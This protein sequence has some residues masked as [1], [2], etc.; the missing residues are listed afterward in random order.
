MNTEHIHS[1]AESAVSRS[2]QLSNEQSAVVAAVVKQFGVYADQHQHMVSDSRKVQKGDIFAAYS[3]DPLAKNDAKHDG[4]SYAETAVKNGARA[5]LWQL[6]GQATAKFSVPTGGVEDLNQLA[7]HIA[8]AYYGKPSEHMRMVAVTGTNGKTSCAQWLAQILSIHEMR[9]GIMGTL[10]VGFIN[11]MQETG[12]TT[13][14]AIEVHRYLNDMREHGA[15]A[16]AME[17]SSHALTQGRVNGVAYEVALF[18]NLSRDHLDYHGDMEGYEAA[19]ATLF[20]WNTLKTAVINTDDAVGVRYAQIAQ[21][22][23][24]AVIG[25]GM[26]P[27]HEGVAQYLQA[28]QID[29]SGAL[30]TFKVRVGSEE[31]AVS[32]HLV[33]EFNVMNMLGVLGVC[34]ALG[35]DVAQC[36]ADCAHIGAAPGRMQRFGG[37]AQPLVVVDFAHTPDALEK[38]LSALRPIAQ[39]RGGQLS[40]VFGCGGDRDAGKRPQMG[41]IAQKIADVVVVTSD[42]PRTESPETIVHDILAGMDTSRA[43]V[44]SEVL[45]PNAIAQ[46][47]AS[48]SARD[49]VL[50]AGKGHE[51]YQDVMGVKHPFS[52]LEEVAKALSQWQAPVNNSETSV[53]MNVNRNINTSADASAAMS[54]IAQAG[55]WMDAVHIQG[56]AVFAQ[57]STDTRSLQTGDLF[58]ALKGERFDAHDFLTQLQTGQVAAVVAERVPE[59]F[60]LPYILVKDT[61]VALQDL[62]RN[63][64]AQFDVPVVVVTGSNGK[65]TVKEMLVAIMQVAYGE[66]YLATRGNFN[67]DIGLPLTLLNLDR[68]HQSAV[69]ELGMNHPGETAQ[70]A[71]IAQPTI[72]LINNAQ[73]EHQEFMQ[74]VEAV[75][76]EHADVI[77]SI[78]DGGVLVCPADDAHVGIWRARAVARGI[79]V[80]DFSLDESVSAM[81]S[82]RYE[83]GLYASTVQLVTPMGQ[84]TTQINVPGVHNVHNALAA[85]AVV[86]SMGLPLEV[87]AKGLANFLPAKGRLQTHTLSEDCI[88][89]DDTYNANPDSVLAA[90]E[91]LANSAGR[92]ILVLGDMAEV[93]E[94]G[95]AFHTEIGAH[96]AQR[97]VNVLLATGEMMRQAAQAFGSGAQHFDDVTGIASVV[98]AHMQNGVNTILVKGSRFMAMERVVNELLLDQANAGIDATQDSQIKA[99]DTS[100]AT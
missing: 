43:N 63:W 30:T 58:V 11:D 68:T 88:L 2:N 80:H 31:Y 100:D 82:A 38:T 65:T 18:T 15:Q 50:I 89:I 23:G 51:A 84:C 12:F 41:A 46:T 64:R 28:S 52:D 42:N 37:D 74:T 87:V 4:R 92:K 21:A 24:I 40:C 36:V 45:R 99:K 67:N 39:Q 79:A 9:C 61:R 83:L 49:V 86:T 66:N 47:V 78:V 34:M 75:A 60:A 72:A 96:A 29:Q 33:G 14:Q 44:H 6:D 59:G 57:V 3:F 70:L 93:G 7:G 25:Y 77:D 8:S 10:G 32:S 1:L 94:D 62:A 95:G 91:V 48:A 85:C 54:D 5:L 13:P 55:A 81:Y 69:I 27:A 97:G 73:R 53:N 26:N 16:M 71:P 90:I 20:R 76:I 19:K 35:L 98:R 56:N 22:C 17:V